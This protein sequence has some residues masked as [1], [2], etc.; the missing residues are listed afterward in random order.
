[1]G[2]LSGCGC[3]APGSGPSVDV[4]GPGLTTALG[5]AAG[6]VGS[7]VGGLTV[8]YS[9]TPT[10][11]PVRGRSVAMTAASIAGGSGAGVL[12]RAPWNGSDCV[13]GSAGE[14]A[15]TVAG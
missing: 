5:T 4:A 8:M 15:S 11:A 7:S 12:G 9:T 2:C 10:P 14:G 1:M 13:W 3:S 6:L